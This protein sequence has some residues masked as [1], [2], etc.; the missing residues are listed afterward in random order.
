MG[1]VQ[2]TH[3]L[4]LSTISKFFGALMGQ[5]MADLGS[6]VSPHRVTELNWR[7]GHANKCNELVPYQLKFPRFPRVPILSPR[8]TFHPVLHFRDLHL[9][10]SSWPRAIHA[11][12][13]R[14]A[15]WRLYRNYWA[16]P[17]QVSYP[18]TE[19]QYQTISN[20][21]PHVG[22]NSLHHV[23]SCSYDCQSSSINV[24]QQNQIKH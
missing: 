4:Y 12:L 20:C 13:K 19:V 14:S 1:L 2:P 22:C 6:T 24:K 8:L 10:H 21:F 18:S 3:R 9:P 17:G 16:L 23:K 5:H 15:Q 11:H 7:K